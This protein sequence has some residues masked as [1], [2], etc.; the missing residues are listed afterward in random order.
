MEWL[1]PHL[2]GWTVKHVIK[3]RRLYMVDYKIMD[4]LSCKTDR[5]MPAPMALFFFTEEKQ[6]KP[7]AIQLTQSSSGGNLVIN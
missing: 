2:E 3:A 5:I 6:L 1:K 7:L 4:G